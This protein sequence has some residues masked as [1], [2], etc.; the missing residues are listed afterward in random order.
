MYNHMG[1]TLFR[2]KFGIEFAYFVV[3]VYQPD[4]AII[5]YKFL[6]WL[7][8]QNVPYSSWQA[9]ESKFLDKK[10]SIYKVHSMI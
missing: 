1:S 6:F 10:V 9:R 7:Q 4:G 2:V 5:Q 8:D 3:S